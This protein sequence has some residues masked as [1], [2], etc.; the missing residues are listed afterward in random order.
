MEAGHQKAILREQPLASALTTEKPKNFRRKRVNRGKPETTCNRE[1]SI[2]RIALNLGRK[3]TPSKVTTIPYF[4]MGREENAREGILTDDQ[5]FKMR[6][7]VPNY[8]R[9]KS[10]LFAEAQDASCDAGPRTKAL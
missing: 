10:G 8:L 5:Y 6:D 1:L 3:C 4:P 9:P 2:P 7:A